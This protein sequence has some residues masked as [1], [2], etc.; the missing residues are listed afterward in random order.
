MNQFQ[1]AVVVAGE[2]LAQ[3]LTREQAR[4]IVS[5][6]PTGAAGDIT[7]VRSAFG[8][9]MFA[10]AWVT[11]EVPF[12]ENL[13]LYGWLEDFD[14]SVRAAK[15]GRIVR[16][17][18]VAMAHLHVGTARISPRQFGYAQIVN[19]YYLWKKQSINS[20]WRVITGHWGRSV[21][22][23]LAGCVIDSDRS[24]RIGRLKGNAVAFWE[25]FNG[26]GAPKRIV[27]L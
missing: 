5:E 18:L 6:P 23:N 21:P 11:R 14:W 16:S 10:R 27:D 4:M 2:F 12:D 3:D 20:L 7:E 22:R 1:D 19:P 8:G 15:H 25:I 9:N 24:E 17:R 13:P 26:R